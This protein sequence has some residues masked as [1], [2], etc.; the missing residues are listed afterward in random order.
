MAKIDTRKI[1]GYDSMSVEEKLEALTAY[2]F[3]ET[4]SDD[5][6]VERLRNALSKAN[7]EVADAKR[8]LRS[9]LSEEEARQADE[10]EA[11]ASLQQELEDAKKSL[12]EYQAK[13]AIS[14]YEKT[15]LGMGYSAEDARASAE[16]L[17]SGDFASFFAKQSSFTESQRKA[18]AEGALN[19]QPGLSN[20]KP[21]TGQDVADKTMADMRRYAGLPEQN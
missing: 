20:G 21:A 2:E 9:K 15:L 5:G 13:D 7:S 8:Q 3:D 17:H 1:K 6:E 18:A 14:G 19:D 16:A 10:A 4:R 12:R 11:R